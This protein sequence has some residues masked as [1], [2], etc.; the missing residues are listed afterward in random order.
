MNILEK[1]MFLLILIILLAQFS[2][3]LFSGLRPFMAK[4]APAHTPPKEE[5]I[6][7]LS[8]PVGKFTKESF[9]KN[10]AENWI[11]EYV[12]AWFNYAVGAIGIVAM[13]MVMWGGIIWITAGG[14]AGQ[15]DDAKG[16]IKKYY[17]R[18]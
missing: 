8:V 10:Y 11:G 16:K 12:N 1:M 18:T 2:M 15:I 14:N 7:E 9:D 6:P 4:A 5:N 13:V 3:M 17:S